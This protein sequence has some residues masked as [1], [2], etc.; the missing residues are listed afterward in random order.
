VAYK[1]YMA[2]YCTAV[3]LDLN[4]KDIDALL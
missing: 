1:G 3:V 2:G 4:S